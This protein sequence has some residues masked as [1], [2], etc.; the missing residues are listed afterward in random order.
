M[1]RPVTAPLDVVAVRAEWEKTSEGVRWAE[2]VPWWAVNNVPALL[3]HIEVLHRAIRRAAD[4]EIT[5]PAAYLQ[6]LLDEVTG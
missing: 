4:G 1:G 2:S 6:C 5:H 3:D